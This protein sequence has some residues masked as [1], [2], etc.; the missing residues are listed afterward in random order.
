M[1]RQRVSL[2]EPPP[3]SEL[4]GRATSSGPDELFR[5]CRVQH[6]SPWWFSS[7]GSGRFD[8]EP[9][10][11]T[12]Y[13]ASDIVAALLEV[14][15]PD[16][17]RG[18]PI[19][20]EYFAERQIWHLYRRSSDQNTELA[21]LL[22][23]SWTAAGVT[24]ELFTLIG[25]PLPRAWAEALHGAGYGGLIVRLRHALAGER[26]GVALFGQEDAHSEDHR[27]E[28]RAEGLDR[29]HLNEF[30]RITGIPVEPP[31]IDASELR[32]E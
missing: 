29:N 26:H 14:V 16:C 28:H 13:T 8:L 3:P 7:D 12:C 32:V 18:H 17:E 22:D 23:E 4:A 11:G 24:N 20:T 19:S 5:C 25:S 31:P 21:N 9:P 30:T 15:G 2:S 27:Y 10:R 1:T 6:E